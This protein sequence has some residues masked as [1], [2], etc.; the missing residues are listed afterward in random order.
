M[1]NRDRKRKGMLKSEYLHATIVDKPILKG[2]SLE[3]S[4]R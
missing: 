1:Q 2:I 3:V 4:V